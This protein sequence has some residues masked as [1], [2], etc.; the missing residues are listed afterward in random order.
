M[1]IQSPLSSVSS[2]MIPFQEVGY[3]VSGF[4]FYKWLFIIKTEIL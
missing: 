4:L 3:L 1:T 2:V